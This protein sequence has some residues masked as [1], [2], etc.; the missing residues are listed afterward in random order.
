MNPLISIVMPCYNNGQTIARTVESIQAQTQADWELIAVDDGSRDDTL[1]VLTQLAQYEPRMHVIHQ[2]N[3]GVS[4]ARNCGMDA[5][6][7]QW[8]FFI[9][10]DDHLLDHAL[11]HLLAM[12]DAQTDIVCGA[13]VMHFRDEGGRQE[14]H[15]CASG[16]LQT[17]LE[18]LI[19]GDSAL[20]SMC[21]RLYR[22]DMLRSGGVRAPL[23][24]KVGED[25]LFNLDAFMA[26]RSW[27]MSEETIYIYEFGGNS[28]MTRA[29]VDVYGISSPMIDG[30]GAFICRHGMQTRLFR[31]HIDIY[32]RTLRAARGRLGAA[33]AL[34]RAMV[35]A[36]TK[37]VVFSDLP[38]KQ[39]L[40]Y[41]ALKVLPLSSYLLP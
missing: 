37:G 29:R 25:V 7:G 24:V 20:N 31:A 3:G 38:A 2:E 35:A 4:A 27:R 23:G 6:K 11:E 40:Y 21:A 8:I 13:Y 9:D 10:A 22:A 17:V 32:V 18:S 39:K 16:D 34:T 19:R 26:A 30:I 14:K 5:A 41:F 33:F 1:S 28:A 36:M 15:V 12:T